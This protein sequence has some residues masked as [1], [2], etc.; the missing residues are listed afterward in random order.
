[1]SLLP[2]NC[3]RRPVKLPARR[4][5]RRQRPERRRHSQV[6]DAIIRLARF[7]TR[8]CARFGRPPLRDGS[9]L[10]SAGG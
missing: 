6:D 7:R 4:S 1:M 10:G 5:C 2:F 3:P 8:Q 9:A